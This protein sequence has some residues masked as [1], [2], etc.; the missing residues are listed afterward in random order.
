MHLAANLALEQASLNPVD[1]IS[2]TGA[3]GTSPSRADADF[4]GNSQRPEPGAFPPPKGSDSH[5]ASSIAARSSTYQSFSR[6]VRGAIRESVT[7]TEIG[8]APIVDLAIG[9]LDAKAVRAR[10]ENLASVVTSEA[11]KAAGE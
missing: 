1:N 2:I 7:A 10:E 4:C 11:M 5:T 8:N 6:I 3:G 9:L